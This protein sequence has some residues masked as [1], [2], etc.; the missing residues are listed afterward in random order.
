[1]TDLLRARVATAIGAQY[2]LQ[3]ELGRGGMAVV[4]RARD[5][6]LKR[7]VAIKVLPP[8]L[9][10]DPAVRTRFT[11]EAQ[12]SAQLAHPHIVQIYDV[13][14]RDGIAFFVMALVTGGT[15][16][17]RLAAEPR[18]P[19]EDARRW[20]AEVADAL[21]YAHARGVVHRDIKPDNV[22]L[23]RDSGRA[24][25]T[26]FGIARAMESGAR[27]T[28]TG[29]AIGTPAYMSPEQA[30]G[31]ATVDG[32]SDL[33]ALGVLGYQMLT[34]R[35]PFSGGNAMAVMLKHA[36]ERPYPIADLRPDAPRALCAAIERALEKAPAD[37][38]PDAMAMRDALRADAERP[39][40]AQR[41]RA[42][43]DDS[44]AP[45]FA[46]RVSAPVAPR[47]ASSAAD[48]PA[49]PA[50]PAAD[51]LALLSA[52]E[53]TDLR[54]WH[55]RVD[56][57]ERVKGFRRYV[58]RT[59]GAAV[60]SVLC[61]VGAEE[62]PPLGVAPLVPMVMIATAWKR[63]RSLKR[64]GVKPLR[65]LFALRSA[66]ALR[67]APGPDERRLEKLVPREVLA[68]SRGDAIRR[69]IG[70]RETI[71]EV[72]GGLAKADRAALPDV[73]PTVNALLER[74]VHLARTA[75]GLDRSVDPRALDELDARIADAERDAG[76]A[77]AD[78]R[79]A[80]LHRQRESVADLDR[81]RAVLGRQLESAVLALTNLR[82]DLLKVRSGGL[83]ASFADVSSATQ[84]ARALSQDIGSVLAAVSE[85]RRL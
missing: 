19:V 32:R 79:L 53:R 2:E 57:L 33:Y 76:F 82:L 69:A 55:G 56:L 54:L 81:R 40:R 72:F 41:D 58:A 13:G 63:G 21:A 46:E 38:W 37:R 24:V 49:S 5:L 27:L 80:L 51:A 44:H 43:R 75:H 50:P 59:L 74:V 26:D 68:G 31:T 22:L 1:V 8:E 15:L 70:E 6:R 16:G 20:L 73:M 18:Q 48:A 39:H 64:Q 36:T 11:R 42:A 3:E 34:G 29:I 47:D 62:V 25:V 35:V 84:D 30:E 7:P 83:H 17:R 52:Q 77:E 61:V 66:R 60:F 12:T 71:L 4:Y 45:P 28:L 9:A 67:T 10:F 78:R 23:D 65:A 85:V 14:E